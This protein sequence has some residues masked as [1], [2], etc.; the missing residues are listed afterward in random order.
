ML[1]SSSSSSHQLFY[2]VITQGKCLSESVTLSLFYKVLNLT[3][4]VT[5]ENSSQ[6][7]REKFIE[8]LNRSEMFYNEQEI[9]VSESN[10]SAYK[11]CSSI[12]GAKKYCPIRWNAMQNWF[13]HAREVKSLG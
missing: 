12:S 3:R 8:I 11:L 1:S 9:P 6:S 5:L 2:L 7:A 13:A 10:E 4:H